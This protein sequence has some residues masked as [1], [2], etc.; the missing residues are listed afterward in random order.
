MAKYTLVCSLCGGPAHYTR[1]PPKSPVCRPCRRAGK[2][3]CACG[4]VKSRENRQ[5]ATCRAVTYQGPA[6]YKAIKN[7]QTGTQ[8]FDEFCKAQQ[9]RLATRLTECV[10]RVLSERNSDL[11]RRDV[12]WESDIEFKR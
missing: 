11:T 6:Y 2:A 4:G 10:E 1:R 3:R 7:R 9:A 12:R 8:T 5:C